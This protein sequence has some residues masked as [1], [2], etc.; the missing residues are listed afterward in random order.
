VSAISDPAPW[1][2]EL[3]GV[4]ERLEAKTKQTRWTAR[5]DVLIER[6]V[7]V[8]A[9]TMRKLLRSHRDHGAPRVPVRRLERGYD[10]EFSRRDIIDA[11]DLCE[12]IVDNTE[13][14]LY[15]GETADL[16]DGFYVTSR[17]RRRNVIL[18]VASDFIALC[19]DLG[20]EN[21]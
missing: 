5:T 11:S 16:Y 17:D 6:D 1:K 15:C 4:A 9:Y 10:I 21:G 14:T 7:V 8:G 2:A 3:R 13:F 18:V 19:N 12:R 20:T